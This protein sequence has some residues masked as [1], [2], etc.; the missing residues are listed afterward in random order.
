MGTSGYLLS[1]HGN[2][3]PGSRDWVMWISASIS[4]HLS[5]HDAFRG[6]DGVWGN[7]SDS[8]SVSA[9]KDSGCPDQYVGYAVCDER[10]RGSDRSG[11][12]TR[13][14][15][16]TSFLFPLLYTGRARL[17][18]P[19]S[20][21]EYEELIRHILIRSQDSDSHIRPTGAQ[22]FRRIADELVIMSPAWARGSIAGISYCPSVAN[23]ERNSL[24]VP[25]RER[26]TCLH[27][28]IF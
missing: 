14:P 1:G 26:R 4:A 28:T 10:C 16:I 21:R 24:P 15:A 5:V 11:D 19:R 20:A 27:Y 3:T 13:G 12:C 9:M 22:Q 25:P 2:K 8:V 23:G 6:I 17:I 7:G 18:E